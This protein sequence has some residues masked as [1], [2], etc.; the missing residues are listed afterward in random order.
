MPRSSVVVSVCALPPVTSM[1]AMPVLRAN[2]QK[3]F[4]VRG[5]VVAVGET[6]EIGVV[7]DGVSG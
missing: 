4:R 7:L 2:V 1:S 6:L 3:P 5:A